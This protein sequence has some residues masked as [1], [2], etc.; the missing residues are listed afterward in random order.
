MLL[1]PRTSAPTAPHPLANVLPRLL[2]HPRGTG[3]RAGNP[4]ADGSGGSVPHPAHLEE[5]ERVVVE[6]GRRVPHD[7]LQRTLDERAGPQDAL[8]QPQEPVPDLQHMAT[9]SSAGEGSSLTA[10]L[11]AAREGLVPQPLA[12][13]GGAWSL[14]L[15]RACT[16]RGTGC[17]KALVPGGRAEPGNSSPSA[18]CTALAETSAMALRLLCWRAATPGSGPPP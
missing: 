15:T 11:R 2:K 18:P 1:P 8:A 3:H 10:Q 13:L 4:K 17:H 6:L 14:A 12:S 9:P 7:V 5:A 16:A